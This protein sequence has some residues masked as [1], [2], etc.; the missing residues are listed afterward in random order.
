M[1]DFE[2]LLGC[3]VGWEEDQVF[4]D[5]GVHGGQEDCS[6]DKKYRFT[7]I[8]SP[9]LTYTG[10]PALVMMNTCLPWLKNSGMSG[11]WSWWALLKEWGTNILRSDSICV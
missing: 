2:E 3:F 1:Y 9:Y 8:S 6:L 5:Y 10:L 11:D 4:L 7:L